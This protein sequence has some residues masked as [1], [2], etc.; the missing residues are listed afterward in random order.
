MDSF[1][2]VLEMSPSRRSGCGPL[3]DARVLRGVGSREGVRKRPTIERDRLYHLVLSLRKEGLS[4]NQIIERVEAEQGV[5]LRKSHVSEWINGKHKPFGYVRAFDA[6][7]CPELA[8]VIGVEMGD[9]S[10]S[11]SRNYNYKLKLRVTDKEF[12]EEFSSVLV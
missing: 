9:A 6:E 3:L 12:A 10:M 4:Y 7:P 2:G 11:F 1:S 8:Y 5:I